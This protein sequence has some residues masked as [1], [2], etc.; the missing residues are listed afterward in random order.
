MVKKQDGFPLRLD[1]KLSAGIQLWLDPLQWL[2]AWK[3]FS[4]PV[5]KQSTQKELEKGLELHSEHTI[6]NKKINWNE[7]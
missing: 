1:E 5:W 4:S 6:S 3:K 7:N 2:D